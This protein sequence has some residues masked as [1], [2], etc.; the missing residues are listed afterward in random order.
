MNWMNFIKKQNGWKEMQMNTNE[1]PPWED[2]KCVCLVGGRICSSLVLLVLMEGKK[3]FYNV[4]CLGCS[5][6]IMKLMGL[7][8]C[9]F[10]VCTSCVRS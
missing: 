5:I 1:I 2:N 10:W 6:P 9:F 4:L 3:T 8:F 7:F